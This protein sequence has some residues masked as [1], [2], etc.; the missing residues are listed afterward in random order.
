MFGRPAG[1]AAGTVTVEAALSL[2][3]LRR[4]DPR[5]VAG[6]AGLDRPIRWAH[7][8]EVPNMAKLLKG[9]ELLLTT[10]MGIGRSAAEQRSFIRG[11][12]ER[13]VAGVII[14][15]GQVFTSIPAA[16]VEVAEGADLPL[17]ELHREVMFVEITEEL[18]SS[19]LGRQLA[20]L[21][22]GDELHRR[23]TGLLLDGSGIPEILGVLAGAIANPVV[24]EKLDGGVLYHAIHRTGDA[25]VLSAWQLMREDPVA[26]ARAVTCAVPGSSSETWGWL[27]ALPLDSPLDDFDQV[28]VE[29]A[30][31]LIA[32]ALMRSRQETLLAT[33]ERGNFLGGLLSGRIPVADAPARAAALGFDQRDGMLLPLALIARRPASD[34]AWAAVWR[35]FREEMRSRAMPALVGSRGPEEQTLIVIGIR[36][37]L[38]R[39]PSIELAVES[40]RRRIVQ[41]I[42]SSDLA[43]IAVGPAAA[44]WEQLPD[45]LRRAV[46]TSEL[47]RSAPPRPWHDADPTNLDGLMLQLRSDERLRNFAAE[48]LAPMVEHDS[49]RAAKLMPTLQVLCN[50]GWRKAEAA[51]VLHLNRQSLYPRLERIEQLLGV[52]LENHQDRLALELALCLLEDQAA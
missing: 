8:G 15:L 24:L 52:D 43:V 39:R 48:R 49:R 50:Q 47:A 35:G 3:S 36:D 22:R 41:H 27:A 13:G 25:E 46:E 1:A 42:G 11:L 9:G 34:P 10:G 33:R 16:I 44:G 20:V 18:H 14:E 31:G 45:A 19:I 12:V 28:A 17:V 6:R 4:G 23:F 38:R 30:V 26:D 29:R 21:R 32:L 51:R 2:P 5:V 40:L 7:S 37:A